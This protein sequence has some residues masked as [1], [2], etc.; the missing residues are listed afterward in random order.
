MNDEEQR[1]QN[2]RTRICYKKKR[3]AQQ[4]DSVDVNINGQWKAVTEPSQ[5]TNA[6]I[7]AND[8]KYSSTN[9]TPLMHGQYLRDFGYLGEKLG[10]DQILHSTYQFPENATTGEIA[11]L[12]ALS[13]I[14][15]IP[16]LSI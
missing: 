16:P 13:A 3:F 10:T 11:M 14:P 5:I 2:S 12:S 1:V 4:L 8:E 7:Q 15:D 9:N 6:I